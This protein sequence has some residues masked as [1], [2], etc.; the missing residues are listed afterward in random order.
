[1]SFFLFFF[2]LAHRWKTNYPSL[3]PETV[4]RWSSPLLWLNKR[5]G[6]LSP[7]K[8]STSDCLKSSSGLKVNRL[9]RWLPDGSVGKEPTCNAGDPAS[10][11]ALGRYTGEGIGYPLQY[12]AREFHGLQSMGSQRV[13]HDWETF[14]FT[15]GDSSGKELT[16]QCRRLKR[17][18]FNPWIANIPWRRAWRPTSVLLP[19]NPLDKGACWAINYVF[20]W[21]D[22]TE[23]TYHTAHTSYL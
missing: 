1:M 7:D 3:L 4:F 18:S 13:R 5:S 19:E 20:A 11:P 10:I 16:C 2:F 22:M 6:E 21:S 23:A 15:S 17:H 8:K 9:P 14:T 12:S